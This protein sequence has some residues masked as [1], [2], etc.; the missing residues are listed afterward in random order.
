MD[1]EEYIRCM[2]NPQTRHKLIGEIINGQHPALI[3][4]SDLGLRDVLKELFPER[5]IPSKVQHDA[6]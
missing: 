5:I 6:S 1:L 4:D 3:D 2:A